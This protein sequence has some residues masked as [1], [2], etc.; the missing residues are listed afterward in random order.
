MKGGAEEMEQIK[1][2][3]ERNIFVDRCPV[4]NKELKGTSESQVNFNMK[5]HLM[6]HQPLIENAK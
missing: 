5:I 1:E 6:T 3:I 4:C 2:T